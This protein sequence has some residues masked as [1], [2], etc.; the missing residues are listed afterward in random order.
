MHTILRSGR[1]AAAILMLIGVA[2]LSTACVCVASAQASS[3]QRPAHAVVTQGKLHVREAASRAGLRA[4][5]ACATHRRRRC[6]R[7]RAHAAHVSAARTAPSSVRSRKSTNQQ[8]SS[9]P[10]ESSSKSSTT[11]TS[12]GTASSSSSSSSSTTISTSVTTSTTTT[13]GEAT[14]TS[15]TSTTTTPS[16]FQPGLNSGTNPT[17]DMPG[18]A[19]LGAKI[20]R[21]E[22]PIQTAPSQMEATVAGYAA[23]GIRIL[24]LAT[25]TARMPTTTEAQNLANWA[26]SYGPGG[27][28]WADRSDGQLAVTSIEF[29]NETSYGYQYDDNA[30]ERSYQERAEDYAKRF[31]EAAEAIAAT[32]IHV[33]LLAQA[34][35]WTG[36]WVSGMYSAVPNLSQYVAGWT[37]HPYGP[38]W[39]SRLKDL[40]EQTTSHG[41]PSTIPIDITEWGL[42]TD[43]G[44]CLTENYGWNPCMTYQEAAETLRNTVSEMREMLGNRLGLFML[45]QVRDQQA[46]GA[47]DEREAYFGALQHELQPKG[48]YTTAVQQLLAS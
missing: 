7:D 40:I 16:T 33:G 30:G 19:Q 36:D 10:S 27:T 22:F 5:R 12:T 9:A 47:S 3:R 29:G 28:F 4:K 2:S 32:G 25:F 1:H 24:L 18:A 31:K 37:I 45:Y 17:F 46:T 39:R 20:V 6:A 43:N 26:R 13:T 23:K 35:D 48:A 8:G 11:A 34:D 41:A 15:E 14:T 38:S 21:I 42:S 44:R